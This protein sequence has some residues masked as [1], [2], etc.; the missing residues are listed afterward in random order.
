MGCC[1]GE[2]REGTGCQMDS[3]SGLGG[4]PSTAQRLELRRQARALRS[5][6][7]TGVFGA[8]R[9]VQKKT[10]LHGG[11]WAF[12]PTQDLGFQDSRLVKWQRKSLRAGLSGPLCPNTLCGVL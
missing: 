11:A 7:S 2:E 10:E 12:G 6:T 5:Q 9:G 1:Q 3:G 8:P 4:P